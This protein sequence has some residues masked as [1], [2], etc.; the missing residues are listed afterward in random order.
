MNRKTVIITVVG[1]FLISLLISLNALSGTEEKILGFGP[2][3]L[4]QLCSIVLGILGEGPLAVQVQDLTH[5][6]LI[7]S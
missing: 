4:G 1:S 6:L 5:P 7:L 3:Q 2:R